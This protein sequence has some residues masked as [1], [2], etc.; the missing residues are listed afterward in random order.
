[1]TSSFGRI[2]AVAV[3]ATSGLLA[4]SLLPARAEDK[5]FPLILSEALASQP[6]QQKIDGSVKFY[7]GDQA[8]PTVLQRFGTFVTNQKT[9]NFMKPDNKSCTW[10]FTSALL[11]LQKRA[12]ALGANAVVNIHSYYKKED[13]TIGAQVPCHVGA[14]IAGVALKGDFVKLGGN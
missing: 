8:H 6:V 12:Q 1:M 5:V 10:V 4:T 2:C 3:L 14:M 13:V 11:E 7:F 9:S